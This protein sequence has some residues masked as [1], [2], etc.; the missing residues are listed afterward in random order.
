M[1]KRDE[2]DAAVEVEIS[3]LNFKEKKDLPYEL[4]KDDSATLN[5]IIP[6]ETT[7]TEGVYSTE[8]TTFWGTVAESNTQKV[9]FT[10]TQCPTTITTTTTDDG[11]IVTTDD[12][13]TVTTDDGTDTT[14][15]STLAQAAPKKSGLGD[16]SIYLVILGA[17]STLVLVVIAAIVI[18]TVRTGN[19]KY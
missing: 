3:D 9:Q 6:I 5:F 2:K 13:T 1:G 19:K 18:Y 14:D 11:T 8:I 17:L 4:E 10:I 16:N 12:G 15:T 7:T